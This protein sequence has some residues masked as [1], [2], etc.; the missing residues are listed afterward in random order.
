VR[1]TEILTRGSSNRALLPAD[2]EHAAYGGHEAVFC[3]PCVRWV[4]ILDDRLPDEA[5]ALHVQGAKCHRQG[6][7]S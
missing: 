5:F 4:D 1:L 6:A 7:H 3:R 2:G